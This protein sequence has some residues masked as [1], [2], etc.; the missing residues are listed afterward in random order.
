VILLEHFKEKLKSTPSHTMVAGLIDKLPLLCISSPEDMILEN[1][2]P[3]FATLRQKH[4]L[5]G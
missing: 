4:V 1:L 3:S 5:D 2:T